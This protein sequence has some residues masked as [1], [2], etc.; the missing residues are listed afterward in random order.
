MAESYLNTAWN[1]LFEKYSILDVVREQGNFIIT[2]KQIKEFREPRLMTKFDH[3]E[4]LP[5][6]FK[7]NNLSIMPI[8]RND[9]IISNHQMFS[10]LKEIN[11]DIIKVEFP[12]Y[13]QSIVPAKITSEAIALNCAYLT[14]MLEDFLEDEQIVPTVSGRMASSKFSFEILNTFS[15]RNFTFSFF[16]FFLQCSM[17]YIAGTG[18]KVL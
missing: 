1:Q 8:S 6:I 3:S 11:Q 2:A 13:I 7:E 16:F 17:N 12:N 5:D 15:T 9:F 14:G 10:E 4:N 18:R